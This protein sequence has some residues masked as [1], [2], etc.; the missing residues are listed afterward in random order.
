MRSLI[1]NRHCKIIGGLAASVVLAATVYAAD[2]P[3]T[4]Q[5]TK[6]SGAAKLSGNAEE[7]SPGK[8]H[9]TAMP[10]D[11]KSF[12]KDAIE[13]NAAEVA[14]AQVAE[15]KAQ[16]QELKKYAQMLRQDH[17]QANQQL[18]PLAQK[19]GLSVNP[20]MDSK[21]QKKLDKLQGLSGAEFDR[22]YATAMLKDHHKEIA[23]YEA[24]SRNIQDPEIQQ[25]VQTTLPKLR[26]HLQHAEHTAQAVGVD[27]AT[28]SAIV[29]ETGSMGGTSDHSDKSL[30]GHET[31]PQHKD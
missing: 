20:P 21:H 14:L 3:A 26:Q 5:T 11:A 4:S 13:G 27:Q 23:K 2:T 18:Q 31:S 10:K 19:H 16:N 1:N 12:L 6:G 17:S 29:K 8:S 30:S 15:R 9:G 7:G 24:A 25:Y 28:I 22:E